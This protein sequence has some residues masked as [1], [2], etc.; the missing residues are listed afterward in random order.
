[1]EHFI[2]SSELYIALVKDGG[3]DA[4]SIFL[5]LLSNANSNGEIDIGARSI[6]KSTKIGFAYTRTVLQSLESN[7]FISK[8]GNG[9][10]IQNIEGYMPNFDEN[11]S[12]SSKSILERKTAFSESIKPYLGKY[13]REFLNEFYLYWTQVGQGER[14]MLFEKQKSFQIPNRLA[15]WKRNFKKASSEQILNS[16]ESKDYTKGLWR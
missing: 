1:M 4:V 10:V 2:I 15:L 7:G 3:N 13:G 9:F 8:R 6:S 12:K 5:F 16:N 14:K 11:L